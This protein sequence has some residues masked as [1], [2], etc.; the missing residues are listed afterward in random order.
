MNIFEKIKGFFMSRFDK[1]RLEK[2]FNIKLSDADNMSELTDLWLRIYSGH[3]PWVGEGKEQV[4]NTL[5]MA[6]VLCNDLAA[7]CVSELAMQKT[8]DKGLQDFWTQEIGREIRT[9]TEYALAGGA[10]AIRPY[11][12]KTLN[13]VSLS[14]YTADRFIPLDWNESVPMSGIFIDRDVVTENGIPVYYTKLECHRWKYGKNGEKGGVSI[15]VKAFKSNSPAELTHSISLSDYPKWADITPYAEAS[16]LERPLFVYM[17]TPFSNN[18]ALNSN[19]GVSLYKDALPVLE[20]I[21]RT[22]DSLCWELQSTQ[23]KVFVDVSMVEV[24][25]KKNGDLVPRFDDKE[26]R[27]YKVMD[28]EGAV[29][30]YIDV[31]SPA[32]RQNDIT[33]ALKT[34]LSLLC[35]SVHLD[36]GSYVYEE[37]SGAVTA[38]EVTAKQQKTYQTICDMQTWCIGPAIKAVYLAVKQMQILYDIDEFGEEDLEVSFGDSILT[39]EDSARENAQKEVV[40]GLRSK[41]S[42]LMDYRGLTEEE[43]SAE[44]ERMKLESASAGFNMVE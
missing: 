35:S 19:A 10:V 32:I 2:I 5:S 37:A 33:Q 22:Y 34:Q 25:R 28:A 42:Y 38:R 21:D 39:D 18:K 13:K 23:N 16:G 8:A 29:N 11:Y 43:A 27:L 30:R 1:N 12:N 44:I 17:K 20:N 41:L 7:K 24:E 31:Y 15:E 36:S 6:S 40:S 26:K 14:W 9:Q 4:L 3:A